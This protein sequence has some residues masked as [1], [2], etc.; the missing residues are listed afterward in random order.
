MLEDIG[1]TR[2]LDL[3]RGLG[4]GGEGREEDSKRG[5]IPEETLVDP[6]TS[7]YLNLEYAYLEDGAVKDQF[8]SNTGLQLCTV[9]FFLHRLIS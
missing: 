3:S 5:E 1:G 7:M 8:V 9:T 6:Q 2:A 4:G